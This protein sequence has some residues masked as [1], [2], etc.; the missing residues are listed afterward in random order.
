MQ[1]LEDHEH[2]RLSRERAEQVLER[3]G[4]P[5]TLEAGR[6]D[7]ALD[8]AELREELRQVRR[9]PLQDASELIAIEA[10]EAGADRRDERC[11][12][13]RRVRLMGEADE[14]AGPVRR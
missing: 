11:V 12:G 1:V 8:A 13:E 7:G 6:R 10:V 2:R 3:N 14:D 9:A 5:V 4:E